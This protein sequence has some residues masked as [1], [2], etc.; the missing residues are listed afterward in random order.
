MFLVEPCSHLAS[1]C[2]V[3]LHFSC[4]MPAVNVPPQVCQHASHILTSYVVSSA[5]SSLS[6]GALP[7]LLPL[8][9]LGVCLTTAG[10][11]LLF[12]YLLPIWN[13]DPFWLISLFYWNTCPI[14]FLTSIGWLVVL[15]ACLMV[16]QHI[17]MKIWSNSHTERWGIAMLSSG[18]GYCSRD[19]ISHPF[20]MT[21]FLF[22]PP[23]KLWGCS[24]TWLNVV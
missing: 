22:L 12:F 10:L 17:E 2:L 9:F 19:T 14:N 21:L 5:V 1:Q 23:W 20:Y 16:Q 24:L 6:V 3:G 11:D 18:D 7:L 13:C 15:P 4:H 8:L